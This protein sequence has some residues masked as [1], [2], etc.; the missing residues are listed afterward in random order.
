[1]LALAALNGLGGHL[2][3]GFH[4]LLGLLDVNKAPGDDVRAGEHGA[5]LGAEVDH[6]DDHAVLGQVLPIPQNH[7]AHIADTA[8]VHKDLTGGNNAVFLAGLAGEF[9]HRA[10]LADVN[11]PGVHTHGLGQL[12]VDL[13]HPLFAV[14][15]QEEP[16]MHQTMDDLQLLPAGMAGGVQPLALFVYHVCTL[17]V[18]LVDDLGDCLLVAGNGGGG[19]DDPVAGGDV[20]LLVG[21]KGHAV[22]RRHIFALRAGGDDDHLVLGQA[23]DGTQLHDGAGLDLQIAQLLGHLQHI[24]H[25]PAGDRHLP[26]MA[27]SGGQNGLD[28]VHIGGEGGD[29]DPLVAVA[30]LPIQTFG[31]QCL[32]WGVAAAL[33]IGG[34]SQQGQNTLVAQLTQTGQVDHA[35][36]GGGVDLKVTGEYHSAHRGLDGKGHRIGDGVVHMD[37]FHGE[38]SGLD[39]I[40]GLVGDQLD[41]VGQLVLLQLHLDQSV[42]HG[43][44]MDG[45]VDLL[46]TVGDGANVVF[47]AVGDEHTPQLLLVGHQVGKVG[48]HQIHAVHILL[49]ESHAAVHDDHILA[50]LQDGTVFADLIQTAQRDNFQFFCQKNTPFILWATAHNCVCGL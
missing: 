34:V 17:A 1:M 33:D 44:A 3:Q 9:K 47:V 41:L 13:Q 37:E 23:L 36:R 50:I 29:D 14:D 4:Q 39:H 26:P 18:Q 43:G 5:V 45:T 35:V 32:T 48:D 6:N 20:H 7:A 25:A 30:E 27:L 21:V 2:L 8:A 49:G 28:A 12:G 42:G 11:V 22:Q 46:H 15:G 31:N 10:D 40:A 38:A 16:G 24:L 19:N